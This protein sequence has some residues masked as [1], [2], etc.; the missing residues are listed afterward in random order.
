LPNRDLPGEDMTDDNSVDKLIDRLV[1]ATDRDEKLELYKEWASRYDNDVEQKGY[2]AP[3]T[4]E[5][6]ARISQNPCWMWP[7]YRTTI[8]T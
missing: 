1:N 8:K 7:D 2:V 6:R 4:A 3:D 5:S